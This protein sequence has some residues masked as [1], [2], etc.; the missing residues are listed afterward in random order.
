M[1]EW[2]FKYPPTVYL[3]GQL[4]LRS[5][6]PRWPLA[7]AVIAVGLALAWALRGRH[8]A[9]TRLSGRWRLPL[10]WLVQ[11][12]MA[13][14]VL[15]LLWRPAIA[16]S[17]LVPQA[18]IIAVLVDDSH[19]M[20]IADQGT[21][22]MQQAS[23][24]L[25]GPWLTSLGRLFQ[26]RLYRFDAGLVRVSGP[27]EALSANGPATHLNAVLNEFV[28]DTAS[29][30]VGAVVLLSDGGD[31][32]GRIERSTIELLRQRR[33][34]VHTVGFGSAQVPRDVEIENVALTARALAH[35]RVTAS[36]EV[37][38]SGFAGRRTSVSVRDGDKLL[39]TREVLLGA[40]GATLS[41]DLTFDLPDAGPRLLRFQVAQLPGEANVRNNELAR[42]V[43]VE[44]GPRR[45][46]YVEGEPR[47][48]Y[49]FIR[50]AEEDD[51]AVQM[52]SMLRTTENK[53]YRQGIKDALELAEGFPTKPEDL[54]GYDGLIIGSV[55]AGWFSA[56]QQAL[57][58]EFVN[59]RGGG[60]LLLG[61]R[62]S[63]AD[64][65]WSGSQLND[66]LP[67]TLPMINGTF[68]RIPATVSLTPAGADSAVTRLVDDRAANLTLWT[69]LPYL[70]D[71]QDPG[72]VKPGATELAQMQVGGRTLPL[73]VTQ[74]YGRGRT[75]VL[76]T[77]GTWRWQMSLPL[78]DP[79]HSVFWHQ[80]LHWLVS[81][82]RGQL[83]AQVSA[84]ILEDDGHVQL[85]ADVRDKDYLPAADAVVNAHIIGPDRLQAD[86][87][88]RAVPGQPGRYQ[89]DWTAPAVGTYVADL[90]ANQG[91]L[92]AGRDTIAFQRQDG[93]A[94]NFHTGQNVAL[95]KSLA[96]D[97][98]GRYWS[99]GDLDGLASAIPFSNAGVSVQ[100]FQDLW[101]MPA[102]FLTLI[103]LRTA[104]WLLRRRWG[105]V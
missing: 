96:A 55:D 19:S 92:S 85:L 88:L 43:N 62:Q 36:V 4:V 101:N 26:T 28:S 41:T 99:P 13:A 70:M 91:A 78:G 9:A 49:K 33:I 8:A 80:L 90:T 45:I 58:R 104:E 68:H 51:A 93:V 1:F 22:R 10:I 103:L 67:V 95:L 20:A 81:D 94:E 59:R 61:G 17:E 15:L 32:S 53:I 52:V 84:G 97:T 60:L 74:N 102:V 16:V 5:A 24:A 2:L 86:V 83:S 31:N 40:D 63:L 72:T 6:W 48:E 34:P 105:V 98:G 18:N 50:R 87:S 57:M 46:L 37:A 66:L 30:P 76:A 56:A 27:A 39:A 64:G 38:Q 79:T 77:G 21:T 14:L 65:V 29:V 47:W 3:H 42:L 54:F 100:K 75:A 35:S 69:K 44:A 7:L 11:W 71:Y 73:L 12:T 25:H 23:Q 82:T 89:T